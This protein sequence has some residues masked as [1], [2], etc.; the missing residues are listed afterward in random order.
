MFNFAVL[1]LGLQAA[2]INKSYF[3]FLAVSKENFYDCQASLGSDSEDDFFSVKGGKI[4]FLLNFFKS[5][6]CPGIKCKCVQACFK[7]FRFHDLK[8]ST[9][10]KLYE[11]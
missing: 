9:L 4:V 10:H 11:K 5:L 7:N 3:H 2:Y 6:S 1:G 8:N